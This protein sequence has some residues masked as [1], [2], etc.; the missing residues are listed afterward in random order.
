[1]I[2]SVFISN[3]GVKAESLNETPDSEDDDDSTKIEPTNPAPTVIPT[4]YIKSID[5][6][7]FHF[8]VPSAYSSLIPIS[9]LQIFS[10]SLSIG[11]SVNQ[12]MSS[13]PYDIS[14]ILKYIE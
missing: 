6:L 12:I 7:C 10:D 9:Y 1:M 2:Y 4:E 8:G 11:A 14:I 13:V 3:C 5:D